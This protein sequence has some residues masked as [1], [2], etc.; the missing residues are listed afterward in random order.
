MRSKGNIFNSLLTTRARGPALVQHI[1]SC[2]MLYSLLK[3]L[4]SPTLWELAGVGTREPMSGGITIQQTLH[5][6][7]V[8]RL[9]PTLSFPTPCSVL[10]DL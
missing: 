2:P 7:R 8:Q 4:P 3:G 9:P 5:S 6:A 10:S 1:D